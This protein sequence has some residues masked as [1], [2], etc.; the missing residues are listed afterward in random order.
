LWRY[1]RTISG[2]ASAV[3]TEVFICSSNEGKAEKIKGSS[4]LGM[5][6]LVWLSVEAPRINVFCPPS[7]LKKEVFRPKATRDVIRKRASRY[8]NLFAIS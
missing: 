2:L 6:S 1:W 3:I 5:V 8:K 4:G 7:F